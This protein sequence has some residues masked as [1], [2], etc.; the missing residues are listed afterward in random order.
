MQETGAGKEKGLGKLHRAIRILGKLPDLM[1]RSGQLP[2]R[3]RNTSQEKPEKQGGI[4][5][6]AGPAAHSLAPWATQWLP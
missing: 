5:P 6:L 1:P 4:L 2:V 3:L